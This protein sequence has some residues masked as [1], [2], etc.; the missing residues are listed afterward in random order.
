MRRVWS[1]LAVMG[2][3]APPATPA[4]DTDTD[5]P[6]DT[7]HTDLVVHTDATD[8]PDTDATDGHTD[9]TDPLA[10]CSP[11][12]PGGACPTP[13][14]C[15][16]GACIFDL[17]DQA[18]VGDALASW[19]AYVAW[20]APIDMH[21]DRHPLTWAQLDGATQPLL[22]A[23]T[24][25]LQAEWAMISQVA[26][27]DAGH[28][29][30]RSDDLCV[31]DPGFGRLSSNL[32][33]CVIDVDGELT[34]Y[35]RAED[36]VWALGDVLLDIDGRS[37]EALIADRIA[38][39]RCLFPQADV[40]R[41]DHAIHTLLW[42]PSGPVRARVRRA[43]GSL[44]TLRVPLHET[45]PCDGRI[46]PADEVTDA[47]GLGTTLL[48]GG[49]L[50]VRL[51]RFEAQG[52]PSW[53][54]LRDAL[55]ATLVSRPNVPLILDIRGVQSGNRDLADAL[56]NWLLPDNTPIRQCAI[57]DISPPFGAVG[58]FTHRTTADPGLQLGGKV[59]VISD[60]ITYGAA[61]F[62]LLAMD[63]TDRATLI[64]SPSHGSPGSTHRFPSDDLYASI[65]GTRCEDDAGQSLEGRP[66][67]ID[68]PL[69]LT[70]DDIVAGVDTLIEAA[71]A[72]VLSP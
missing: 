33:A 28:T 36:A 57:F 23:A 25:R 45:L 35:K 66:A 18:P 48:P 42:R 9:H 20:A 40:L 4:V 6:T 41:R 69:T 7:P 58:P 67:P 8:V 44:K 39:P 60:G 19:N 56:S 11:A 50:L 68:L 30:V 34:V 37:A 29:Y 64:G 26:T 71:R 13:Q 5:G 16:R 53:E 49:A 65:E 46:P 62:L 55:R 3:C 43:D 59:A 15:D 52:A 32:G 24:T 2:A 47:V 70:A 54:P 61:E 14:V 10:L 63:A 22:A 31:A 17:D 51:S 27:M 72:H 38:Q 21:T 1:M 12:A